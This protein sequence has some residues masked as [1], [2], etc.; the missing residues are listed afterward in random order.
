MNGEQQWQTGDEA[1]GYR[2]HDNG[3][4]LPTTLPAA[5]EQEVARR[6]AST[7]SNAWLWWLFLGGVN[8]H[9][10]YLYPKHRTVILILSVLVLILTLGLSGLFWLVS[11]IWL[12]QLLTFD[13]YKQT[14]REEVQERMLRERQ[15]YGSPGGH[16][17]AW[18][19]RSPR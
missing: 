18:P 13:Q 4:W 10:A 1:N 17:D 2:L 7:K 9:L 12:V 5:V 19:S 8:A 14:I 15:L 11:W 6:T 3:T 16:G